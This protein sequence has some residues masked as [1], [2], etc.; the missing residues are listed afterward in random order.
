MISRM[1]NMKHGLLPLKT[2]LRDKS[3]QRH[4]LFGAP[5]LTSLPLDY[6]ASGTVSDIDQGQSQFCTDYT[7][8]ALAERQ[9][10]KAYSR[11]YHAQSES[12]ILGYNMATRGC[13]LRT[14]FKVAVEYGFLEK[15]RAPLDWKRDGAS[16]A[17]DPRRWWPGLDQEAQPNAHPG[18]TWITG[19][20]DKFDSVRA[21]IYAKAPNGSIS[22]GTPWFDEWEHPGL[23]GIL[24]M[25]T[26]AP[27][28]FHN[29]ELIGWTTLNGIPYVISNSW[30]GPDFGLQGVVLFSREVL[31]Y[32]L[33]YS[34]AAAATLDAID[35][36]QVKGLQH[37]ILSL[38]Q[39]A[40]DGYRSII[41]NL[42]YER[43]A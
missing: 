43:Q 22:A 10:S 24:P 28:G 20:Y 19:P 41:A 1:S 26:G 13:D 15:A 2:D 42:F 34:G 14:A 25:P 21:A 32:A 27:S 18:Y 29:H 40:I 8:V 31:N 37:R 36:D 38:M 35:P 16:I 30:Q 11:E 6:L 17:A 9:D 33:T 39:I 3:Y 4:V 5:S 7:T 12:R 23:D